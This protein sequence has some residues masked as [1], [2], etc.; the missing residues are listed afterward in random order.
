MSAFE[1][2]ALRITLERGI[3]ERSIFIQKHSNF[4][5]ISALR[6][7]GIFLLLMISL[8]LQLS[9]NPKLVPHFEIISIIGLDR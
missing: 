2:L 9:L 5:D 3:L 6:R 8:L 1:Q 7:N 4:P